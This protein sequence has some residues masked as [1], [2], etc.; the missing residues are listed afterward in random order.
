MAA[1]GQQQL[2]QQP[3]PAEETVTTVHTEPE[4]RQPE[5][6]SAS[7]LDEA[8]RETMAQDAGMRGDLARL[9]IRS[10]EF[11]HE[12]RLANMFAASGQFDDLKKLNPQQAVATALMKIEIGKS[13]GLTPGLAMQCVYIVKGVPSIKAEVL[14]ARM[15]QAG[16]DWM[17]KVHTDKVCTIYPMFKGCRL[18]TQA[19]DEKGVPLVEKDGSPKLAPAEVTYTIEDAKR[20][21]LIKAD[22]AWETVPRNMLF[23]RC[24]SNMKRFF[25]PEVGIPIPTTEEMQDE[26]DMPIRPRLP[27]GEQKDGALVAEAAS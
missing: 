9:R 18:M 15:R 2:Q 16:Y 10:I 6:M 20:A 4:S 27:I 17:I 3:F 19:L 22:G 26:R 14:A 23:W 1:E 24:I 8:V 7:L 11:D 12:K 25:A 5:P 21:K 13:F